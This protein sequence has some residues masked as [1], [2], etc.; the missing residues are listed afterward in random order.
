VGQDVT[1]IYV[2]IDPGTKNCALVAW[3]P[4]RGLITT[5]KPKGAMPTGVMRLRRLMVGIN[6]ELNKLDEI[7][8]IAMEA[9]SM[10]EKYGQHNSGEVGAA[11]KLTILAHFASDDRRAFP[12]LVAPQQLKKFASGNGNTKKE[13]LPKEIFKRWG[14][15]FNDMNIAEAY[16]LARI[17]HAVSA[18]PEMTQFQ[19]SVV[20]ALDGR[21]EWIP[22]PQRRLVRVGK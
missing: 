19:Q 22:I 18:R 10:A 17:A 15:D 5:W 9:Y 4:T 20:D 8:M 21:T 11:I 7:K 14:V 6:D 2:G 13:M 12:V 1:D 16:V 3:S